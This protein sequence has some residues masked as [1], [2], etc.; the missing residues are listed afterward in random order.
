MFPIGPGWRMPLGG[1]SLSPRRTCKSWAL[2]AADAGWMHARQIKHAADNR[3]DDATAA[4]R[5]RETHQGHARGCNTH[6]LRDKDLEK[7]RIMKE[8]PEFPQPK[9]AVWAHAESFKP[10]LPFCLSEASSACQFAFQSAC[11]LPSMCNPLTNRFSHLSH[12]RCWQK[13][14]I[15]LAG[16]KFPAHWS[17]AM[18]RRSKSEWNLC[19]S[20]SSSSVTWLCQHLSTGPPNKLLLPVSSFSHPQERILAPSSSWKWC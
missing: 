1:F 14:S 20:S 17:S 8:T 11:T 7:W 5:C 18:P 6:V 15:S 3:Q 12:S 9:H 19:S 10:H 4:L 2:R 13:Q 16:C